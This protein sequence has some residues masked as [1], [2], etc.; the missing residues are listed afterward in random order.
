MLNRSEIV[1]WSIK[2]HFIGYVKLDVL[3]AVEKIMGRYTLYIFIYPVR[4]AASAIL[5]PSVPKVPGSN[6][7]VYT[8]DL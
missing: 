6:P 2:I 8:L 4:V 3:N 1:T 7:T 5:W